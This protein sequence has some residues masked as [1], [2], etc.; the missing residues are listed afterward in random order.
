MKWVKGILALLFLSF[1][2]VQLDDP[3]P[4]GWVAIYLAI[5][6]ACG[7]AAFGR[8]YTPFVGTLGVIAV[9]WMVGLVPEVWDWIQRGAPNIAGQMKAE[10]PY[11]EFT[12]EFFGLLLIAGTSWWLFRQGRAKQKTAS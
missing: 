2:W 11:I 1:A 9:L 4:Y 12:R 5:A 8:Y 7:M 10:S 6:I 3:D